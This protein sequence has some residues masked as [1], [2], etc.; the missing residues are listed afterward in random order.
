MIWPS[1]LMWLFIVGC[2]TVPLLKEGLMHKVVTYFACSIKAKVS[3]LTTFIFKAP[4]KAD[5]K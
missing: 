3:G 2:E 1:Y 5:N 4:C